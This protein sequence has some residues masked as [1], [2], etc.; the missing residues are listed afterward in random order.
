MSVCLFVSAAD[1]ELGRLLLLEFPV[2]DD[3]EGFDVL[4][5]EITR[6][7]YNLFQDLWKWFIFWRGVRE[8]KI[9]LVPRL[10]RQ[11]T[12]Q[13]WWGFQMHKSGHK[14]FG[15]KKSGILT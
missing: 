6:Q 11:T 13:E 14:S 3:R 4:R 10:C 1:M 8:C 7:V 2:E 9:P 12:I 15:G 5:P